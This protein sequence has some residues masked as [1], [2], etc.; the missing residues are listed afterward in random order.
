MQQSSHLHLAPKG[1]LYQRQGR[2]GVRI[3]RG[4]IGVIWWLGL[5][6]GKGHLALVD[7]RDSWYTQSKIAILLIELS[8]LL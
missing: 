5:D 2:A 6:G 3:L 8:F 1:L 7:S 4:V